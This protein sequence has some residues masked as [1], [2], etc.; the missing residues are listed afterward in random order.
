[1]RRVLSLR[2]PAACR[3]VLELVHRRCRGAAGPAH[4]TFAVADVPQGHFVRRCVDE[5]LT[6]RERAHASWRKGSQ[7]V[8]SAITYVD[9]WAACRC[10]IV[11]GCNSPRSPRVR[12]RQSSR[13]AQSPRSNISNTSSLSQARSLGSV[14]TPPVLT[15][16]LPHAAQRS[17]GLQLATPTGGTLAATSGTSDVA[18][19]GDAAPSNTADVPCLPAPAMA[20]A[21]LDGWC[22]CPRRWVLAFNYELNTGT[23]SRCSEQNALGQLAAQ[24]VPL[25]AIREVFVHGQTSAADPNPLFPCGV[26]ENMFKRVAAKLEEKHDGA[27]IVLYMFDSQHGSRLVR[28]QMRDISLRRGGFDPFFGPAS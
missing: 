23:G 15:L 11:P 25:W 16:A 9:D 2:A 5:L 12:S 19:A 18:A 7:L 4:D 24:G 17:P 21:Q 20:A 26:C 22:E 14:A 28:M 1:M 10:A 3:G 13:N 8:T 27:D 6:F